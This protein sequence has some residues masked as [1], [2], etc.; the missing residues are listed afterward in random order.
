MSPLS[1]VN[2]RKT[3]PLLTAIPTGLEFAIPSV[4]V[5]AQATF[6]AALIFAINALSV[7]SPLKVK[8]PN[9]NDLLLK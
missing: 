4:I 9:S 6:P 8:I 5:L 1:K 7:P 3:R 2:E